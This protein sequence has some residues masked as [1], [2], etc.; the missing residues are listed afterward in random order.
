MNWVVVGIGDVARKR[1][2][3]AIAAEPR[4]TLYGV[5]TRD[6]DK[7]RSL[8]CR[9]W[10][11][12][13]PALADP[14]VD[15]IY[16]A[17]P[18]FLHR[19][20]AVAALQAGKHVLCEKPAALSLAEAEDMVQ[21]AEAA[22]RLL[23]IAYFRRLYPKLIRAR[24]LVRAGAIGRVVFAHAVCAEWPGL[25]DDR[26]W[27]T[28]PILAGS[29]PLYDI[30]SHRIDALDF[31]LGP[32]ARVTAQWSTTVRPLA[33]EDSATVLI[34]YESGAR[35]MVDARWNTR[36]ALDELRLIGTEDAL[37]LT[38][39]SGAELRCGRR[40]EHLPCHANRHYPVVE[41]FVSAVRGEADLA[42]SGRAALPTSWVLQQALASRQPSFPAPCPC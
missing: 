19:P 39:S 36:V 17:T 2:L 4:S 6:P 16:L 26:S 22:Q 35:A 20:Q 42:C 33:V 15:A 34:E 7:A 21:A 18:V 1:I 11:D 5:V 40:I 27:L 29:G 31:L 41:N 30:G 37:D 12:L 10:S 23:G 32:P 9:I 38:A 14:R 13:E 3:P 24:E 8:D 25:D 28:D